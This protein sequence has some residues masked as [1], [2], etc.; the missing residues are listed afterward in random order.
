M[1]E[2]RAA[3]K[4]VVGHLNICTLGLPGML[5]LLTHTHTDTHTH[6]NIYPDFLKV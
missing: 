4:R 2:H 5:Y 3:N 6:N 1:R